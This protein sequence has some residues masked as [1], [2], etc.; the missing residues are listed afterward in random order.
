MREP[1]GYLAFVSLRDPSLTET[2]RLIQATR[3]QLMILKRRWHKS[4]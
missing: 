1:G 3:Q 4:L 2:E